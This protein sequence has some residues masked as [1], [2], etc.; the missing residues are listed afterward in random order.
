MLLYLDID[1]VLIPGPDELGNAPATHH[2]HHV[3]PSDRETPVRI[4]LNPRHGTELRDLIADTGLAPVWCTSWRHD[5]AR[6]IAP[7]L[8][9]PDWPHVPLPHRQLTT[10]HPDGYLWKRDHLAEHAAGTPFAWI[11]DDFTAADHA[12]A[13]ART[14]GGR[15]TLLLQPRHHVGIRPQHLE[16]V[17]VWATAL[18]AAA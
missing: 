1:G 11:D 5:A 2:V 16:A 8:G 15:P 7:R 3:I 18:A 13:T 14:S 12:W 4:W 17:R 9:L 6:L 10:S